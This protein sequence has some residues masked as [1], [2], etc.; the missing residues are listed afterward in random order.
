MELFWPVAAVRSKLMDEAIYHCTEKHRIE[1]LLVFLSLSRSSQTETTIQTRVKERAE[2]FRQCYCVCGPHM[3][4]NPQ[5]N[6]HI[7]DL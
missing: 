1:T 4:R 7:D 6:Y 5:T 2:S 3:R